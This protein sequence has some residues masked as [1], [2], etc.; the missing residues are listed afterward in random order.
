MRLFNPV[1]CAIATSG[2]CATLAIGAERPKAPLPLPTPSPVAPRPA[3][4][5]VANT[6][7][8]SPSEAKVAAMFAQRTFSTS[9]QFIL[10][11]PDANLRSR[12]A[13]FAEEVKSEFLKLIGETDHWKERQHPIVIT[14]QEA[15]AAGDQAA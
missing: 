11:C 15:S 4:A 5:G 3:N 10:Y 7:P 13:S 9:Q 12:I 6:R 2:W 1:W 14:V 8:M